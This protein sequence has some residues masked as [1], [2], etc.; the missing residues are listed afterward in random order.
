MIGSINSYGSMGSTI[1]MMP[2]RATERPPPPPDKDLFQISDAD[3]D[4]LVSTAELD[5]LA[6]G[7]EE[8]TGTGIDTDESL[9]TF[10]IDQDGSLNGEELRGLLEYSGLTHPPMFD[11]ENGDGER[12]N[13]SSP[14]L[15]QVIS[16]YAQNSG[17]N[18]V[19]QL[20]DWIKEQNGVNGTFSSIDISA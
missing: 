5:T 4:G 8:I 16:S 6:E 14:S 9:S 13:A 7:I 11:S 19:G 1:S 10:D 17:E 15:E 18:K 2:G 3:K 20:I 12:M